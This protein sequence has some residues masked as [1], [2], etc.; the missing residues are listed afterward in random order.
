MN[1]HGGFTGKGGDG[2]ELGGG[3]IHSER[4]SMPRSV[5]TIVAGS[6][7]DIAVLKSID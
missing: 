2:G 4:Y 1:G 7:P 3:L 5:C 6:P